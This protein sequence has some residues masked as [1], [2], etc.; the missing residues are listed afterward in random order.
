MEASANWITSQHELRKKKEVLNKA[1]RELAF[2]EET[3]EKR[4]KIL[5]NGNKKKESFLKF[6]NNSNKAK[7]KVA[8]KENEEKDKDDNEDDGILFDDFALN[9]YSD[10]DYSGD[11]DED[12][13]EPEFHPVKVRRFSL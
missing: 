5:Q 8:L 4:R 1:T 6:H 11:E 3:L 12:G 2:M 7:Q 9:N 13:E 10:S